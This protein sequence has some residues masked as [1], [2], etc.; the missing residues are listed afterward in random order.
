MLDAFGECSKVDEMVITY[1]SL[2]RSQLYNVAHVVFIMA[3][4]QHVIEYYC[5]YSLETLL[6]RRSHIYSKQCTRPPSTLV[7]YNAW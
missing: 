7:P 2:P 3:I 1:K 4:S 5:I 6:D